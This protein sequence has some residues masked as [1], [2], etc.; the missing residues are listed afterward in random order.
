[1]LDVI[2][3]R[4]MAAERLHRFCSSKH[5]FRF[6]IVQARVYVVVTLEGVASGSEQLYTR[7]VTTRICGLMA[8]VASHKR[9]AIRARYLWP[10]TYPQVAGCG[11]LDAW[12][13]T[14]GWPQMIGHKRLATSGWPR[15]T[16]PEP[17]IVGPSWAAAL[18][19]RFATVSDVGTWPTVA[20]RSKRWPSL[21]AAFVAVGQFGPTICG[22][23]RCCFG[24]GWPNDLWLWTATCPQF[25]A[26]HPWPVI[27]GQP[28]AASY[29]YIC[30]QPFA[31]SHLWPATCGNVAD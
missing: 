26:G 2:P 16:T 23:L 11:W 4:R 12:L 3:S 31:A 9:P 28:L 29:L 17:Q 27:C 15:A 19:L 10:A 6:Q 1:L 21:L 13:A 24:P 7:G 18:L 14:N 25:A 8:L 30:G 22:S 20:N 5:A